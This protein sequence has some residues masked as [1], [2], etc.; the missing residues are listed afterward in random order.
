MWIAL[1]KSRDTCGSQ[2]IVFLGTGSVPHLE[3]RTHRGLGAAK[4]DAR[5]HAHRVRGRKSKRVERLARQGRLQGSNREI[6]LTTTKK[7]K[8]SHTNNQCKQDNAAIFRNCKH[9]IN[10][11]CAPIENRKRLPR[12]I[13]SF[14][15]QS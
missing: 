1:S 11:N 13:I 5:L 6:T 4:H 3:H 14:L 8:I 12:M 9:K 7:I 15:G 2:A 10:R